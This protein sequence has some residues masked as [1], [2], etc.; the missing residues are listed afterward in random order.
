MS[1]TAA[2]VAIAAVL[3]FT[4]GA[5][6][7]GGKT[8]KLGDNFFKPSKTSVAT[9]TKVKFKWTGSNKHNVAKK[10]GPG[11][12]FQSTTTSARGVQFAKKF[13]KAGTY[14]LIC[15]VHPNDMKLKL[16]VG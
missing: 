9:G 3:A 13:K 4:P 11:G 8:V 1:A 6:A 15:T 10:K 14:K 2:G 5:G 7:G 16:Q 12:S